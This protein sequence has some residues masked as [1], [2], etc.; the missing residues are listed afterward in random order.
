MSKLWETSGRLVDGSR[1]SDGPVRSD[2]PFPPVVHMSDAVPSLRERSAY[3]GFHKPYYRF[4]QEKNNN[5]D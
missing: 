1:H 3:A 4:I 2:D 5:S